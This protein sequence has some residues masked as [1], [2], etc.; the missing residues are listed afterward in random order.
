MLPKQEQCQF[1]KPTPSSVSQPDLSVTLRE[2]LAALVEDKQNAIREADTNWRKAIR[3]KECDF[4]S[5]LDKN[6]QVVGSLLEDKSELTGKCDKLSKQI[7][8]IDSR[9]QVKLDKEREAWKLDLQ[10]QKALFAATEQSRRDAWERSKTEELKELTIHGLEQEVQ[11]I[12]KRCADEKI[13]IQDVM[14]RRIDSLIS[15]L[16]AINRRSAVEIERDADLRSY[17]KFQS[18]LETLTQRFEDEAQRLKHGFESEKSTIAADFAEQLSRRLKA[19]DADWEQRLSDQLANHRRELVS[20]RNELAKDFS[21]LSQDLESARQQ[22]DPANTCGLVRQLVDAEIPRRELAMVERLTRERD[23][24]LASIV[25]RLSREAIE[26][27]HKIREDERCK[28]DLKRREM[29]DELRNMCTR[30]ES[31]NQELVDIKSKADLLADREVECEHKIEEMKSELRAARL[32]NQALQTSNC[33]LQ[34]ASDA[35]KLSNSAL[36]EKVAE[37]SQQ[38]HGKSCELQEAHEQHKQSNDA[39]LRTVEEELESLLA[40]KE[41]VIAGLTQQLDKSCLRIQAFEHQLR[42]YQATCSQTQG[43]N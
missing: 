19:N 36:A 23:L 41:V 25:D 17:Q 4:K 15:E 24:Q 31:A 6:L 21:R 34:Q 12:V 5:I 29:V 39:M 40:Q 22:L 27:E 2:T 28:W 33:E 10:K 13:A 26:C 8:E 3:A 43:D 16:S 37:L 18:Q 9:W 14:Q 30:L 35:L 32:G 38:L 7:L 1:E 42:E 11:K 20:V